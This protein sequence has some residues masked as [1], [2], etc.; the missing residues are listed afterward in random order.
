M[1]N[2]AVPLLV[3]EMNPYGADPH[4]ALFCEPE[5]SAG[6]RLCRL[7]CALRRPTYLAI[8]RTNLCSHRWIKEE[9]RR[10]AGLMMACEKWNVIIM[11]GRKVSGA[12]GYR[13]D[14]FTKVDLPDYQLTLVSLPH[15]SGRCLAWNVPGAF[16]RARELLRESCP[17]VPWGETL[18]PAD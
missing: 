18:R 2:R 8:N 3:G 14:P 13:G 1:D 5:N 16:D 11:L 7:V 12:F 17:D 10:R 4:Y 15:P 9:A 6:G